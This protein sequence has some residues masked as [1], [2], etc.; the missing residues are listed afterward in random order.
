MRKLII[1]AILIL[2][3]LACKQ[4]TNI[5]PSPR[6]SAPPQVVLLPGDSTRTLTIDGIERSYILHIPP[7][8]D[9]NQPVPIVLVFHGGFGKA[10]GAILMSDFSG[11]SDKIGFF[12]V[13]PNGSGRLNNQKL[14]WNGGTCCGYAQK[15]NIDDV[16]FVRA[17]LDDLRNITTLDEKRIYAT[18][19]SNG[20]M[21][22]YRLACELPDQIAAIGSV[23]GTKNFSLCDPEQLIPVIHFHGTN[24]HH[25]P[26]DGGLG[27]RSLTSV[28]F[29]SVQ[30]TLQFWAKN[31]QCNTTSV[32]EFFNDI[33]HTTYASCAG[34]S[35]VELYTITDGGHAWPGSQAR[36]ERSDIPT[37][38]ISATELIWDFFAAHP[39]P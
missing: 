6:S 12:V 35:S 16:A 32:V 19:F 27:P 37:Q 26:Y 3:V 28:D 36:W 18:G 31:N 20:G 39:Q 23:S 34:G 15:N 17:V 11:L 7:E 1:V 5:T 2:T 21:M 22:A 4:Q 10:D 33:I 14:T 8:H 24:D 9:N 30:D 13:Y 25:V 38:T 29:E